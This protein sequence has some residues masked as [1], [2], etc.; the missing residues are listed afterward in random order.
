MSPE[1]E[2]AKLRKCLNCL[3]QFQGKYVQVRYERQGKACG[4]DSCNLE[5]IVDTVEGYVKKIDVKVTIH[6]GNE[7][8]TQEK[9]KGI[10]EITLEEE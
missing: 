8:I 2:L 3:N 5:P 7:A 9:C 1:E 4:S 10:R 6:I